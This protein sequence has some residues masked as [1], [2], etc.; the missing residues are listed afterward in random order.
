MDTQDKKPF[1]NHPRKTGEGSIALDGTVYSTW[2][3]PDCKRSG[4]II[5][6]PVRPVEPNYAPSVL[7]LPKGEE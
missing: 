4:E 1:C 2:Y 6:P 3:C 7:E 5:T